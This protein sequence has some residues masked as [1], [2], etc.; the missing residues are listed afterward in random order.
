[1]SPAASI[2]ETK[3]PM[4]GTR[5]VVVVAVLL[6]LTACA[7]S[8]A[9]VEPAPDARPSLDALV[10]RVADVLPQGWHVVESGTDGTPIGWSGDADGLYVMVEDTVTR[11]FHPNGFHY[12]SFYRIWL[13]PPGW[14]GVMRSTPYVSDSLPAY[15]LG[16]NDDCLAFY[17]TAGGN[18]WPE[19]PESLCEA[20]D[21]DRICYRELSRRVVDLDVE[22]RLTGA[23]P[24]S[25]PRLV[26][27]PNRILGLAAAGP[28]LYLEYTFPTLEEPSDRLL[29]T[30]MTEEVADSV[31]ALIPEA[32]SIYLR[33]C[34]S[35]AYTDTILTRDD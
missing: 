30:A 18:V 10:A 25:V 3:K 6:G 2:L 33:R 35:D 23:P 22:R 5:H 20:L 1:V 16:A 11:F 15:L 28:N 29:L 31:F 32:E 8:A 24:D 17:H 12:Y 21:L 26:L 9:G 19:G 13:M 34:T 27:S 4:L 14:E 7:A